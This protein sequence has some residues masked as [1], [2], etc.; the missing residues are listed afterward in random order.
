MTRLPAAILAS[1]AARSTEFGFCIRSCF[2]QFKRD[3]VSATNCSKLNFSARSCGEISNSANACSNFSAGQSCSNNFSIILRRCEK[4]R[5]T[6]FTKVGAQIVR[7][8]RLFAAIQNDARGIHV[9]RRKKTFRRNLERVARLEIELHQQR[10][11][12]VIVVVGL[13]HQ[14]SAR[15]RV[16][17]W[18]RSFLGARV[19][20]ASS[21]RIGEA[22][23]YG[24]LA[25][26]FQSLQSRGS[27][28]RNSSASS[29]SK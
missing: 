13:R 21:T 18:R 19:P 20:H 22:T 9:R 10:Q 11:H 23:E 28:L 5:L 25:T 24:R 26:S 29:W 3:F 15:L 4:A 12:A 8:Q 2:T 1:I 6:I 17:A 27:R 16:G 14:P 7:Q